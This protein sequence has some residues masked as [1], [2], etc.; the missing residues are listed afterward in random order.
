MPDTTQPSGLQDLA[1]RNQLPNLKVLK[2]EPFLAK[3]LQIMP[4]RE[5]SRWLLNADYSS[6]GFLGSSSKLFGCKV[7]RIKS[8]ILH[9]RKRH[10]W[11]TNKAVIMMRLSH[12]RQ[13]NDKRLSYE[14]ELNE[15]EGLTSRSLHVKVSSGFFPHLGEN[16]NLFWGWFFCLFCF[17]YIAA[18]INM[19]F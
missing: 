7:L 14:R 10:W 18:N 19:L 3:E 15:K 16:Y 1:M 5:C 17:V 11:S 12:E 9:L 6:S 2:H 8:H 4:Y 13:L